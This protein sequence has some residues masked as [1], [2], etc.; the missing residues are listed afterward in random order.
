MPPVAPF[1]TMTKNN[2]GTFNNL[3]ATIHFVLTDAGEPGA[4][5]DSASFT[6][7]SDSTIVLTYTNVLDQSD[8]HQTHTATDSKQ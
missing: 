2:I 8:N 1:N 3:P 6:I 5:V 7:V 4:G